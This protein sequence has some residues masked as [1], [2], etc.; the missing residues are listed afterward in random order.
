MLVISYN[1]QGD[2]SINASDLYLGGV[3]FESQQGHDLS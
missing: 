1:Q 3:R 2:S